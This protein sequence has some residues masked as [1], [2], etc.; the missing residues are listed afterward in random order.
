MDRENRIRQIMETLIRGE[1]LSEEDIKWIRNQISNNKRRG[2]VSTKDY[3]KTHPSD[4]G[5][6]DELLDNLM[7]QEVEAMVEALEDKPS[8]YIYFDGKV[9]VSNDASPLVGAGIRK[10]RKPPKDKFNIPVDEAYALYQ[11]GK[12]LAEV[13]KVYG[14]SIDTIRRR[15]KGAGYK[16]RTSRGTR[17][18]NIPVE[19]AYE[20]YQTGK[21]LA[22]IG[23]VYGVGAGAIHRRFKDIGYKLRSP[24]ETR[25]VNI[26]TAEAY[27]L[28]QTGK[29]LAEVS[30]VYGVSRYAIQE[31]FK[32]AGYK[33]RT[34]SE[35]CSIKYVLKNLSSPKF[36][37][38][39][40]P[41]YKLSPELLQRRNQI[42]E[43]LVEEIQ[44]SDATPVI[45]HTMIMD[46]DYSPELKQ[47][48]QDIVDYANNLNPD[49]EVNGWS[50]N[51]PDCKNGACGLTGWYWHQDR[52]NIYTK[53]IYI[54]R[55]LPHIDGEA[56]TPED[57]A[58]Y[59]RWN[60][61]TYILPSDYDTIIDTCNKS[62]NV[63]IH[64][65]NNDDFVRDA[66]ILNKLRKQ[67]YLISDLFEGHDGYDGQ[68]TF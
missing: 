21:S 35:A 25:E 33:I 50:Y 54:V 58:E 55:G 39:D 27:A 29:T 15:F 2:R 61:A 32:K 52:T 51:F 14:V 60:N 66:K 17:G 30:K 56:V 65:I 36:Q 68:I 23:K 26:Q 20:L 47:L 11:T 13:G 41:Q 8:G 49:W 18:V 16:I 28:Y 63:V 43:P 24:T 46:G 9:F 22:D 48:S 62:Y 45:S 37:T 40:A 44:D 19:E 31:H 67:G 10:I 4:K 64:Y 12:T 7:D 53:N 5:L 57:V 59:A 1:R 42:L 6:M 34:L 3:Q 38:N